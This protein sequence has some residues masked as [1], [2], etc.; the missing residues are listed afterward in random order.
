MKITKSTAASAADQV[1]AAR[2]AAATQPEKPIAPARRADSVHISS[3]GR[4]LAEQTQPVRSDPDAELTPEQIAEIRHRIVSGAYNSVEVV[5]AVARRI[6]AGGELS[7]AD[8]VD[9]LG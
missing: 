6:L 8:D 7:S 4:A 9:A 2:A 3:A 5:D 1:Q